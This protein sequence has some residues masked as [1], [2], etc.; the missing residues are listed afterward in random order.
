MPLYGEEK[1]ITTRLQPFEQVGTAKA[2]QPFPGAGQI[3]QRVRFG[4]GRRVMRPV[5]LI[6][7]QTVTWQAQRVDGVD[8][9]PFVERGVLI[10]DF[11]LDRFGS[12][13]REVGAFAGVEQEILSA[14][15]RV[16]FGIVL[17]NKRSCAPHHV[18]PHQFA[19]VV[20]PF[21]FLECSQCAW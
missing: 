8:H 21:A 4:G 14:G 11:E 1:R 5:V 10:V 20:R 16:R 13:G 19:P 15:S 3:F 17:L 18:Q 9:I 2:H 6:V 12:A 7:S